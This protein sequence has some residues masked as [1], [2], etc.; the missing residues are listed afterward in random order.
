MNISCC[1]LY[2]YVHI[3]HKELNKI[4]Q[5]ETQIENEI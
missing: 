4:I 3:T 2:F 1:S 5:I